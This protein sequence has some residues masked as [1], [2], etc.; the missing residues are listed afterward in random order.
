[1][2]KQLVQLSLMFF[3]IGLPLAGN[4]KIVLVEEA[5]EQAIIDVHF[6]GKLDGYVT[7]KECNDCP[8]LKLTFNKTTKVFKKG[9]TMPLKFL[10]NEAGKLATVIFNSKSKLVTKIIW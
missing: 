7:V 1:M 10:H 4:A 2:K 5:V 9:K 3:L 6:T 8:S